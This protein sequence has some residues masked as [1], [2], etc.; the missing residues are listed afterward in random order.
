MLRSTSVL[1]LAAVLATASSG[2]DASL[3]YDKPA[4]S[5]TEALPVGNG[6]LAGMIFGDPAKERIQFNEQTLWT[7][8]EIKMGS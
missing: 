5:W 6:G 8:D 4:A 3:W 7:G 2:A 1:L